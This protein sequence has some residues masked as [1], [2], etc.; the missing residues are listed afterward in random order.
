M[1]E[2]LAKIL[3]DIYL[4]VQ[5]YVQPLDV[6]DKHVDNEESHGIDPH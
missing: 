5:G 2:N 4:N 6:V 1:S 3:G